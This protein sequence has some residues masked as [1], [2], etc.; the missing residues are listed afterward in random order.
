MSLLVTS[1]SRKMGRGVAKAHLVEI[2]ATTIWQ[3]T[4]Q[5]VFEYLHTCRK[6]GIGRRSADFLDRRVVTVTRIVDRIY[7]NL[8]RAALDVL[9]WRPKCPARTSPQRS[10][11]PKVG[12][13]CKSA[14]L[15][16]IALVQSALTYSP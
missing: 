5:L 6:I 12:R 14:I 8:Q 11:S 3:R 4:L 15:H 10:R 13:T 16:I 7:A 1:G 2:A 9:R